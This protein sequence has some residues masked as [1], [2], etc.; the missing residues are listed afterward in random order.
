MSYVNADPCTDSHSEQITQTYPP[1]VVRRGK[2]H[3]PLSVLYL[4]A[5]GLASKYALLKDISDDQNPDV[6]ITEICWLDVSISDSENRYSKDNGG[7]GGG[8]ATDGE[9]RTK[10]Y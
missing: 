3:L 4:N 8:D 1:T 2:E 9:I 10:C 5:Q 6:A 7:G